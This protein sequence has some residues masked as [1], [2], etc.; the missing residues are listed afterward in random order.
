MHYKY[1]SLSEIA[2]LLPGTPHT[3]TVWRWCR[4]GI[5]TRSGETVHL[6]HCRIGGKLFVTQIDLDKFFYQTAEQDLIGFCCDRN[7]AKIG[8]HQNEM[9]HP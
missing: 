8:L 7:V 6:R 4:N 3:S 1:F 9:A 5:H 2:Q